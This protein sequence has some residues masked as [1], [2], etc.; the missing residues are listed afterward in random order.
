MKMWPQ[1]N[2][3]HFVWDVF[4]QPDGNKFYNFSFND[5]EKFSIFNAREN[6]ILKHYNTAVIL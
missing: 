5:T 1:E 2:L 3:K 4:H 6:V